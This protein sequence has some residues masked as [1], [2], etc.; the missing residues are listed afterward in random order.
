MT[1]AIEPWSGDSTGVKVSDVPAGTPS[2]SRSSRLAPERVRLPSG[3]GSDAA[4]AAS[5]MPWAANAAWIAAAFAPPL[6]VM[7]AWSIRWPTPA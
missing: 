1:W 6:I 3:T 4:G 5:V 2:R 7:S